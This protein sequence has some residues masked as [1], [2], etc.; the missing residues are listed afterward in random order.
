MLE[1]T[2]MAEAVPVLLV[3]RA[4]GK[5]SDD[6]KWIPN[7]RVSHSIR[8]TVQPIPS[9]ILRDLPEG[10]R[11]QAEHLVWALVE[12]DVDDV[13][14]YRGANHRILRVWKRPEGNFFRAVAGFADD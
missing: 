2:V 4:G 7:A 3:K 12:L 9:A 6:G 14:V 11:E 8:A 5:Y 1:A 10:M 13:V